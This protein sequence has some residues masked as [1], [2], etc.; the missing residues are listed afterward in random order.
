MTV[1]EMLESARNYIEREG[2]SDGIIYE[3][4]SQD[5][6]S[7]DRDK[8]T[9]AK[10]DLFQ[11]ENLAPRAYNIFIMLDKLENAGLLAG[12]P[13]E[14]TPWMLVTNGSLDDWGAFEATYYQYYIQ[15][16]KFLT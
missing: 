14:K 3:F 9:A 8:F 10:H 12:Q 15:C 4:L 1:S 7:A 11:A 5:K 16:S 2:N 13:Y 6:Y